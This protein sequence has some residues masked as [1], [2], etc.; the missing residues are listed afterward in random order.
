MSFRID[1]VQLEYQSVGSDNGESHSVSTQSK[2]D[3]TWFAK[4][5]SRIM[6]ILTIKTQK[7]MSSV[8]FKRERKKDV[9]L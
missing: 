6:D 3:L 4:S 5:Y 1:S 9:V 2:G 8:D 7:Q